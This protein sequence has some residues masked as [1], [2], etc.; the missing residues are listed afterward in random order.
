LRPLA[1]VW[2]VSGA[3]RRTLEPGEQKERPREAR[4]G[5]TRNPIASFT[6]KG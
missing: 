6:P 1:G 3:A 2:Y 4:V 5:P